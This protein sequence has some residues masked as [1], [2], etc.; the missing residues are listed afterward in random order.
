ML[1]LIFITIIF[2]L[3]W[4]MYIVH[5]TSYTLHKEVWNIL[6]KLSKI[7]RQKIR[8]HIIHK[9]MSSSRSG[10]STTGHLLFRRSWTGPGLSYRSSVSW[11]VCWAVTV[12]TVTGTR[13]TRSSKVF[14]NPTVNMFVLSQSVTHSLT[15]HCQSTQWPG[16]DGRFLPFLISEA[17]QLYESLISP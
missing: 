2:F 11:V 5:R 12:N 13:W 3:S 7:L 17:K 4:N 16:P 1:C 6:D 8:I 14:S 10:S 9:G 15:L